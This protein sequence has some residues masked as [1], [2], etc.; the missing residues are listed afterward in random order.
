MAPPYRTEAVNLATLTRGL[1]GVA[2][3]EDLGFVD[4]VRRSGLNPGCDFRRANM[5]GADLR[6]QD[7]RGFDFRHA[8]F[9]GA[10]I[11]GALFQPPLTPV[12]KLVADRKGRGVAVF[13]G[14]QLEAAMDE[15]RQALEPG[16]V[17][18][19]PLNSGLRRVGDEREQHYDAD[20]LFVSDGQPTVSRV[21]GKPFRHAQEALQNAKVA[22]ILFQPTADFDFDTLAVV[23]R[24]IEREKRPHLTFVFPSFMEGDVGRRLFDVRIKA[25]FR[26][27]QDAVVFERGSSRPA[28]LHAAQDA[29][30]RSLQ[31]LV[32]WLRI[33]DDCRFIRRTARQK[34]R[35]EGGDPTFVCGHKEPRGS[36][37]NALRRHI[38]QRETVVWAGQNDRRHLFLPEQLAASTDL[39]AVARFL[40]AFSRPV[41]ISVYPDTLGPPDRYIMVTAPESS[42]MWRLC[43]R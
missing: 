29:N 28:E 7:L 26:R 24:H 15:L 40:G 21:V 25:A 34:D 4:L 9:D 8:R 31:Y 16:I 37:I 35:G 43:G 30:N 41:S 23:Q 14:A 42:T 19:A 10:R 5:A 13:V 20:G 22:L 27:P 11:H 6:G 12:Q 18:P 2:E 32:D 39:D 17:A 3:A 1:R 33:L 38:D 36:L